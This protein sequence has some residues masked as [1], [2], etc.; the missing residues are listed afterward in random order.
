MCDCFSAGSTKLQ[1][2]HPLEIIKV[3]C[4]LY[5]IYYDFS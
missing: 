1:R 2:M 5:K 3:I 4:V